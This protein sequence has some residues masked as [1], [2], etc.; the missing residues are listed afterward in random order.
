MDTIHQLLTNIPD[1]HKLTFF[2]KR[3]SDPLSG[4]PIPD[5]KVYCVQLYAMSVDN[6]LTGFS[7]ESYDDAAEKLKAQMVE[8]GAKARAGTPVEA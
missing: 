7:E 4:R 8:I 1:N 6:Q 2:T 5:T 3:K